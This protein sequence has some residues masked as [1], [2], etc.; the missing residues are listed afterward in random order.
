MDTTK[1]EEPAAK[2][3][4]GPG[5]DVAKVST[6][7]EA[8]GVNQDGS[9]RITIDQLLAFKRDEDP[10]CIFGKRWLCRGGTLVIQGPTGVGKSSLLM[11]AAITWALGKPLFKGL[12]PVEGKKLKF[13]IVQAENDLG[14]L[15]E[16]FQDITSAMLTSGFITQEDFQT[17]R[18]N[19]IFYSQSVKRGRPFIEF[20]EKKIEEHRPDVVIADPL[21]SYIEGNF[22]QQETASQFLRHW[23]LPVVQKTGVIWIW[24]HHTGKPPSDRKGNEQSREDKKYSGLSSSELQNWAREVVTLT[25]LGDGNFE[26][27]FG[28]RWRRTGFT[29]DDGSPAHAIYLKHG[30]EGIVWHRTGVTSKAEVKS[31]KALAKVAEKI[32]GIEVITLTALKTW[33]KGVEGLSVNTVGSDADALSQDESRATR[34]YRHQIKLSDKRGPAQTV[35]ST[36]AGPEDARKELE[37]RFAKAKTKTFKHG[38]N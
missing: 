9:V 16:P 32:E 20:V 25:D 31:E 35:Y 28:K 1:V 27:D 15:A 6:V 13:L 23:L 2:G 3:T 37:Y 5:S 14:D 34:I 38:S 19:V 36:I 4:A 8:P 22:L 7:T 12:E 30:D 26:L 33:A 21:L 18:D 10:D 11:Q 29:N 24:V 17:L